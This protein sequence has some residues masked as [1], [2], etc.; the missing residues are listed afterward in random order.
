MRPSASDGYPGRTHQ[1]VPPTPALVRWPFGFGASYGVFSYSFN[2]SVLPPSPRPCDTLALTVTL[3]NTGAVD[4]DEVVQA[5]AALPDAS[6]PAPRRTLVDFARV[7]V[8][9]G[10]AVS[11][12]LRVTPRARSV[13][14]EGDLARVTEPGR[15]QLWVG[16]CSDEARLPG[17]AVQALV[18]GPA[19][20]LA[21][22][23]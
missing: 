10:G 14:R 1:W 9:A 3:A 23:A 11:V 5:Y 4:A 16:G 15:V 19:V 20:E 17:V 21:Q 6:F 8:P 13:L 12:S 2:G 18:A 22:C 7:R